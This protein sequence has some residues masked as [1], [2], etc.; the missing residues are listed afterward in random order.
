MKYKIR[1]KGITMVIEELK[2]REQAK[3]A[4]VKRY[5]QRI[6]QYRQNRMFQSDQKKVLYGNKPR[7]GD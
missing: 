5:K 3:I 6:K 2:Q 1:I 7:T 4:K